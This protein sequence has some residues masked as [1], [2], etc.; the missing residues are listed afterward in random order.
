MIDE[1]VNGIVAAIHAEF[2]D[3]YP[4]YTEHTEQGLESPCFTV[5]CV[6]PSQKQFLGRR[7]LRQNLF[8]INY[9]P[10]DTEEIRSECYSVLEKLLL[11]LEVIGDEGEQV[12][13]TRMNGRIEDDVLVFNINYDL[14]VHSVPV[15]PETP[16]DEAN[17]TERVN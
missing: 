9:F 15:K 8:C 10:S 16:M 1:I 17:I 3:T 13:G 6:T 2:G 11:I 5:F 4:I 7:Y 12:R 14:F